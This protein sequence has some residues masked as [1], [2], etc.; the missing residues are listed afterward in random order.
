MVEQWD[1]ETWKRRSRINLAV[2]LV[3]FVGTFVVGAVAHELVLPYLLV[4]VCISVPISVWLLRH[5]GD[6]RRARVSSP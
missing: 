1:R 4:W 3:L 6:A 5:S 2:I